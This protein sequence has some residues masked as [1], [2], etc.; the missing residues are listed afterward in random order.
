M[1]YQGCSNKSCKCD[2]CK[3]DPC[4]CED[5]EF[6]DK[7][8]AV[9]G[10][11]FVKEDIYVAGD[12]HFKGRI[13]N[14]RQNGGA[15][16]LPPVVNGQSVFNAETIINGELGTFFL[17]SGSEDETVTIVF[18]AAHVLLNLGKRYAFILAPS[19]RGDTFRGVFRITSPYLDAADDPT[20]RTFE[21]VRNNPFIVEVII[22]LTAQGPIVIV[23]EVGAILNPAIANPTSTIASF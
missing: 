19:R 15:E 17:P 20:V 3:C 5:V 22:A 11:L 21:I 23:F 14:G 1:A 9:K 16:L 2:P 7:D 6:V 4:K 18:D 12:I 8:L 10:N 13:I